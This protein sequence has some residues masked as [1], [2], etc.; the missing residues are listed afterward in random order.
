MHQIR[1]TERNGNHGHSQSVGKISS[2]E[3]G[4]P[5]RRHAFVQNFPRQCAMVI[6]LF[7]EEKNCDLI[8]VDPY[9]D[10]DVVYS[11]RKYVPA[12]TFCRWS[13]GNGDDVLFE[14]NG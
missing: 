14:I 13:G 5:D 12:V 6:V 4:H 10:M 8:L 1:R 2:A 7:F 3:T 9:L 11:N